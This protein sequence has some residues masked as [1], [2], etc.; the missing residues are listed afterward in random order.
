M[1]KLIGLVLVFTMALALALTSISCATSNASAPT[2]TTTTSPTP[3]DT[4]VPFIKLVEDFL[5]NSST[6]KFDGIDNSLK[7]IE[8]EDHSPISSFRAMVFTYQFQTRHPGHGDRSCQI[9]AQVITNH[10]A[11]IYVDVDKAEVRIAI[12]DEVWDMIKDA[13]AP[14]AAT[15]VSG[16]VISGGDTTPE[17][18]LDAPRTFV[19]QL[20]KDDHPIVNV[21]YTAYPPSPAGD[22]NNAK[23]TLNLYNSGIKVGD[24]LIA[25]GNYNPETNTVVVANEGNYITTYP[26]KP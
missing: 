25:S 4:Q 16:I 24:Y 18:L 11:V 12:C 13:Q 20:E 26:Q 5:K 1:K 21:S 19:Y 3:I 6:F 8:A 9:L 17:G 22:V 2:D 14:P 15:T 7:L 10:T 23:I